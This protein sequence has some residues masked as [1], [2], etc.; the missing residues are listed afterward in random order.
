MATK[1]KKQSVQSQSFSAYFSAVVRFVSRCRNATC[2]CGMFLAGKLVKRVSNHFRNHHLGVTSEFS[3][4][5]MSTF[6]FVPESNGAT[7]MLKW[8]SEIQASY[9]DHNFSSCQRR[10]TFVA[11]SQSQTHLPVS[12]CFIF[13]SHVTSAIHLRKK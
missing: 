10:H 1:S 11:Q 5:Q 6:E 2:P 13:Q 9:N 7:D 12:A 8:P 3:M 4:S